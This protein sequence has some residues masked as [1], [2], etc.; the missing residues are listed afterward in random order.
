MLG[1]WVEA[2]TGKLEFQFSREGDFAIELLARDASLNYS[3]PWIERFTAVLKPASATLPFIG[4]VEIQILRW[5][6]LFGALAVGGF[7]YVLYEIIMRR[8]N[9]VRAIQRGFNP[10]ISG[11]P[12][13]SEEMF[14]GRRELLEQIVSTL[15]NNS[16][17]IHGE[18][19]IGKTTILYQ[20]AHAL[21][22]IDDDEF[23]FVPVFVDLE[24][25]NEERLFRLLSEEIAHAAAELPNLAA[26]QLA[27]LRELRC[28]GP[29]EI[30]Y[31]DREFSRD[32]R[33]VLQVLDE[34]GQRYHADRSLRLI[35]LLDEM[36][37]LNRFDHV[38]QQ[39]LR[40]MFMRDFSVTLGAV[41][42]GIEISKEWDRV[43]SPWFNLFNE[44]AMQPFGQSQALELLTEPVR[45]YYSFDEPAI[46]FILRHSD[47]R[48]YRIQQYALEAVNHML[49]H[50]RRRILMV[51]VLAAHEQVWA[52]ADA[53]R[54]HQRSTSGYSGTGAAYAR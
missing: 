1:N 42:A 39:Q 13:R 3:Q 53:T 50:G 11:E 10:Y 43:E 52:A 37:T 21:R 15:H 20:L 36:D 24:G 17:M 33:V 16:I 4:Q 48:P 29:A 54:L 6:I 25:T 34:Y 45:G 18:R 23:W 9:M 49:R 46:E 26:S 47:G 41:V 51:D 28:H 12:V 30:E 31:T 14:F 44:I 40:R 32:L 2:K 7:S 5:L 8:L 22:Q 19:R 38:Y 27:V 35:L